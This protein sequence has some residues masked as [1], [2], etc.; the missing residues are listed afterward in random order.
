MKLKPAFQ[1]V[2]LLILVTTILTTFNLHAARG[3]TLRYRPGG[4]GQTNAYK[5]QIAIYDESGTNLLSGN[6]LQISRPTASNNITVS[7]RGTLTPRR[8]GPIRMSMSGPSY[9][10]WG[11]SLMLMEGAEI[12]IDECGRLLRA[13]NEAA[14]PVPLGSIAQLLL[15]ELPAGNESRWET[16]EQVSVLDEPIA[17]GPSR[18]FLNPSMPGFAYYGPRQN[19]GTLPGTCVSRFNVESSDPK[20]AT[21]KL[22]SSFRTHL[23]TRT[24]PRI[25]G[26]IE[27]TLRVD[28]DS[29]YLHKTELQFQSTSELE[30]VTRRV[31]GTVSIRLLEG[32]ERASALASSGASGSAQK[33][34]LSDLQ[35]ILREAKSDDIT[36]RRKAASRLQNAEMPEMLP[37]LLKLAET[38]AFD[39]DHTLKIAGGKILSTHGTAEHIPTLL[40]L[41][42]QGDSFNRYGVIQA[43][44]RLKDPRAA[45]PLANVIARGWDSYQAAEA[46]AKL[47]PEAED[48]T[49]ELLKE[50]HVETLRAACNILKQIGTAKSIEPIKA[51]MLDPDQS[52]SSNAG[53]AYRAIQGRQ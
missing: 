32:E 9:P 16:T 34:S 50:K 47:G 51:L 33:L 22:T 39:E 8:E 45:E 28:R 11:S 17:A 6:I 2:G 5:V 35:E 1:G 27:G 20:S 18:S 40:K 31:N 23:R 13:G 53:E 26:A 30:T 49:L 42:K 41:L 29:G 14:L 46:L 21:L 36:V 25:Q 24:E 15:P 10:R 38:W 3:V 7:L 37:E 4:D 43:L 12:T 44:G 48:A 19:M 52:L